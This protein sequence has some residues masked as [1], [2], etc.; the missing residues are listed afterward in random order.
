MDESEATDLVAD[1]LCRTRSLDPSLVG[2]D[3]DLVDDL[4]FDS[5]DAA[6]LLAALHTATGRQVDIEDA[7]RMRTVRQIA[8]ALA[9][10]PEP[11]TAVLAPEVRS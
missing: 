4:G 1:V 11:V 7:S 2:P 3:S 5:L 6:E 9:A 10:A 8:A